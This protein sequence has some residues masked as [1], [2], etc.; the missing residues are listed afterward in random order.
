MTHSHP[1]GSNQPGASPFGDLSG[2]QWPVVACAWGALVAVAV[3]GRLWQPEWN[4]VRLWN[5]TPLIAVALASGAMF[6]NRLVAASVPLVAMVIGNLAEKPHDNLAI[7]AVVFAASA[8]PVLF[9]GFVNRGRW[10]AVLGASVASSLVFFVSTNAAH[11]AFTD[12]YARTAAGL[13]ECFV[14][15]LPFYRPLG[16]VAWT[17]A[18]FAAIRGVSALLTAFEAGTSR[19][20]QPVGCT[21]ATPAD[22]RGIAIEAGRT[23]RLD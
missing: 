11:W 3:L 4:G 13:V 10:P 2:R 12:Q 15:A 23:H 7:A 18:L 16:D 9:G 1:T 8:W 5:V 14:Q 17:I 20:L 19:R 6:S 21:A 22:S